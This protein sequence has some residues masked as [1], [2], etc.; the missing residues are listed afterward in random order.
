MRRNASGL[1]LRSSSAQLATPASVGPVGD[2]CQRRLLLAG[3]QLLHLRARGGVEV[4]LG[5]VAD[6]AV[7]ERAP[8]VDARGQQDEEGDEAG[9][10]DPVHA[11]SLADRPAPAPPRPGAQNRQTYAAP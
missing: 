7:A 1:L 2:A 5:Q 3:E 6:E 10:G 11:D 4:A 9:E 8:R